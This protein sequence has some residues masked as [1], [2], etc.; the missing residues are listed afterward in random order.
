[1][2]P[3]LSI[4]FIW[5]LGLALVGLGCAGGLAAQALPT[6]TARPHR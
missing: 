1:M 5:C 4:I 6:A 2:K 3:G